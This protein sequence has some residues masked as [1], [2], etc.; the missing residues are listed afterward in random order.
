MTFAMSFSNATRALESVDRR[1]LLIE[2]GKDF[3]V[4]GIALNHGSK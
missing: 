4:D 3:G 2:L 1:P